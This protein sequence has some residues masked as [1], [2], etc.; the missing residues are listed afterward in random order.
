M[1]NILRGQALITIYKTFVRPHQDYG[2]ILYDLAYNASFHQK[3][4]KKQCL[5][6]NNRSYS[7]YFERKNISR[8]ELGLEPIGSRLCRLSKTKHNFCKKIFPST[9]IELNNLNQDLTNSEIYTLFSSSI[10]KFI[11]PSVNNYFD[12]QKIMGIKS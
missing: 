1:Q 5:Y 11:R 10:L 2:D 9:T 3:L 8:A 7:W 4:E 6:S 12:Y